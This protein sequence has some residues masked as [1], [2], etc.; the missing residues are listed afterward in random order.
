MNDFM[1]SISSLIQR[2]MHQEEQKIK[3][4]MEGNSY[5]TDENMKHETSTELFMTPDVALR[6][7]ETFKS[8]CRAQKQDWNSPDESKKK[9]GHCSL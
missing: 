7:P 5:C 9:H 6:K 4:M 3:R 2:N 1:T 8:D